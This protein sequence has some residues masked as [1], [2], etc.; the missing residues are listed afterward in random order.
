MTEPSKRSTHSIFSSILLAVLVTMLSLIAGDFILKWVL[1]V[2]SHDALGIIVNDPFQAL[3]ER[4]RPNLD[5][6]I[7]GDFREFKYHLTTNN[8]GFRNSTLTPPED[9]DY[10]IIFLGDS[11]TCGIGVDDKDTI[12]A[13]T[14]NTLGAKVL[15]AG[16]HGYSTWDEFILS[17][18]IVKKYKPEIVV[19]DFYAGNDPYQDLSDCLNDYRYLYD[20]N[21]SLP[22]FRQ[23]PAPKDPVSNLLNQI[24]G[25]LIQNSSIFNCI[26]RLSSNNFFNHLLPRLG[27][28]KFEAA[29]DINVFSK[30]SSSGRQ[31]SMWKAT[32]DAILMIKGELA[33]NNVQLV[34]M[35]IPD[36]LQVE[37]PYWDQW[38]RKYDLDPNDYDL[39]L[40]NRWMRTLCQK[41]RVPFIDPTEALK[42][43]Y[44]NG[45]MVYWKLDGHLTK[46]G[47]QVISDSLVKHLSRSL[48]IESAAPSK[49]PLSNYSFYKE[50]L[51][52]IRMRGKLKK[53]N[54]R[55]TP[56]ILPVI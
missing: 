42:A 4:L 43:E 30:H 51:S 29:A 16:C 14:G 49:A 7:V 10:D 19:L 32:R 28:Y 33:R 45:H 21:K 52:K 53:V 54:Y 15:N 26:R 25:S 22:L 6:V 13:I 38:A 56:N 39:T 48:G 27:F 41:L 44:S 17:R 18:E 36:R 34:V 1:H 3:H 2:P 35:F 50:V 24:K 47:N 37:S 46:R 55:I 8:E 31:Q 5:R 9:N 12:P 23:L 40:P 20:H 11:M